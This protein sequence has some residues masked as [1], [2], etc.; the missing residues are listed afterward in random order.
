MVKLTNTL[1]RRLVDFAPLEPGHVRLYTCGPTVYN[2]VHIGNLR[3]FVFE[4]VLRR[5]FR[6]RGDRVTQVMNL[7]D[8]DDKTIRGAQ[9][10]SLSLGEF[11]AKYADAFF[12]DIGRLNVEPAEHYPK[13]TDHVP[14]MIEVIRKLEE[15]GH[16]Y[17]SEGSVYF[18]IS[19]FPGYGKLSGIDL[20]KT[21]RG[22]RVADDEYEKEDVKDF[23]LWKAAKPGEPSWP[24]PW[25]QG[26]PGWHI[27]CS[28]M[29]MKY[30]GEHFDIHTGAVDNIFPHHE[31]EI[32]QSEGATGHPF[33][34]VWL[35]A[36]HLIVDGEKMS[37]SKGNFYT[38]DDVL[39]RRDD[40]AAVRYLFLSVPYRKKLNFTWEALGAAAAAVARIR[41]AAV[42]ID[43]LAAAATP[44]R[45]GSFPSE[46]RAALFRSEFASGMDD[47]LNTP[48]AL[49][50]VFNYLRQVN[51]AVDDGSLDSDG[52][53]VARGAL[54]DADRVLGVL[55]GAPEVLSSE[56][57][58]KIA[59]RNAARQRRD[60][61][62]ADRIRDELGAR[63]IVLEDTPGGTRWKKASGV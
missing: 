3:T 46:E 60:F 10:A 55:P 21:R 59:E 63:G 29:S 43:E 61:A 16:T 19:T 24:S 58:E 20:E 25:G 26:R 44:P 48:E 1:G 40:P 49:A 31:N 33:V 15:R 62:G 54:A 14:E 28:A 27:E 7:T 41:S 13:A 53:R 4:D 17:E 5:R 47:D 42:R 23:A 2:V 9:E 56:I 36:E 11:T 45:P 57:E 12:R 52:A 35:H 22:D 6:A 34:E 30:L 50:A 8:V 18:R 51:A 38:L 32:A 37:K 39:E